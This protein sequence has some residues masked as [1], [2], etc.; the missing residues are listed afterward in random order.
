MGARARASP[1]CATDISRMA[2]RLLTRRARSASRSCLAGGVRVRVRVRVGAR[3]RVR[4][5]PRLLLGGDDGGAL[6][7]LLLRLGLLVHAQ[8]LAQLGERH[9][10]EQ[11]ELRRVRGVERL[12]P[13][14][15]HELERADLLRVRARVRAMAMARVR[16]GGLG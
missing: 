15:R 5:G 11:P 9:L 8:P 10:L 2:E 6:E 4:V 12:H 3:A 13:L 14:A 7:L 16:V 1:T